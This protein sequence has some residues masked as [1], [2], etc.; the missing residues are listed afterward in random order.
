[1]REERDWLYVKLG[2]HD[3]TF[4]RLGTS[5]ICAETVAVEN[6]ALCARADKVV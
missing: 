5:S 2:T 1:M 4:I 6:N 3:K